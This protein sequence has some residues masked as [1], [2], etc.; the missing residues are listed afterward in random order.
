VVDVRSTFPHIKVE[1]SP[2]TRGRNFVKYDLAARLLD[3][4]PNGFLEGDLIVVA[5][6]RG[7]QFFYPVHFSGKLVSDVQV[8]PEILTFNAIRSGPEVTQKVIVKGPQEFR[9]VDVTCSDPR[10]RVTAGEE[11][12]KVHFIEVAYSA[13]QTL[14]RKECELEIV[15]DLNKK[16][17]A[18]MKAIINVVEETH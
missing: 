8:V 18:T 17:I 4:A 2:E 7:R 1:L 12:K 16:T 9:I 5:D 11:S 3:S 15:T 13:D 10:F 14:G 6:E